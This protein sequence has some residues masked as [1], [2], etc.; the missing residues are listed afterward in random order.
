MSRFLVIISAIFILLVPS[1]F[2]G[3][4]PSDRK[5]D[6]EGLDPGIEI[7][8]LD[9]DLFK[10]DIDSIPLQLPELFDKYGEFFDIFNHMIIRIGDPG[11]PSYQL[12]LKRFLTD[13]DI[14]RVYTEVEKVFPD[15]SEIEAELDNAFRHFMFY[16][17]E[18]TVPKVY[19]YI[20]G[21]NQSVVTAEG[22]LGIGLDK[23]LGH[24]HFFYSELQLPVYQRQKMHPLKIPSDCMMSWAMTEFEFDESEGNLLS[25]LVYQGKLLFFIDAM[26]P[27]QH[28]TLKTGISLSGLEWCKGNEA[29][30]WTYLVENKLL[31][32][33]DA[34]AIGRFINEGPYTS[35]FSRE[36]PAKAAVWLGWQI[37]RSYMSRHKDVS[38]AELMLDND[39]QGILNMA[40]YRP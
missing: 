5:I 33:T 3:C 4:T 26:L 10:I 9:R 29:R 28:D 22:I 35:E 15:L 27:G 37:V 36:A 20:S 2:S 39:Y 12:H 14:Y 18:Y 30:M 31:F 1:L 17:P 38:L 34:K 6:L 25:H 24:D 40:R 13:F 8:R 23:Y 19:T 16:F 7:L 21:F 11:S 32:S